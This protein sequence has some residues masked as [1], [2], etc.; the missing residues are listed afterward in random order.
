MEVKGREGVWGEDIHGRREKEERMGS[1]SMWTGEM[2]GRKN[3]TRK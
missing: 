1:R 2:I 3:V